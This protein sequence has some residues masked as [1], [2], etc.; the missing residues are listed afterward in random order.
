[1]N[2]RL[3]LVR[4]IAGSVGYLAFG[5]GAAH[6]ASDTLTLTNG[7]MQ[8]G[9]PNWGAINGAMGKTPTSSFAGGK[10]VET[11]S[12]NVGGWQ[13]GMTAITLGVSGFSSDPG[14]DWLTSVASLGQSKR[15]A[16]AQYN[17]ANGKATWSW[18]EKSG[19]GF[20]SKGAGAQISFTIDHK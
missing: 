4:A 11:F 13:K 20:A 5:L 12:E 3:S 18:L 15:G 1:M 6:A 2:G 17:F 16:S 10:K 7:V 9:V 14:Q 19:F 8:M